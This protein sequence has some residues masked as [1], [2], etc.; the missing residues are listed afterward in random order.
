VIPNI[1]VKRGRKM[2]FIVIDERVRCVKELPR[3]SRGDPQYMVTVM[4]VCQEIIELRGKG[5]SWAALGEI[6]GLGGKALR[7]WFMRWCNNE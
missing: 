5:Y 7:S 1:Y 4:E 3:G 2:N 6:Y